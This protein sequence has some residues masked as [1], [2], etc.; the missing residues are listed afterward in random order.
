MGSIRISGIMKLLAFVTGALCGI[1]QREGTDLTC[2]A[3]SKWDETFEEQTRTCDKSGGHQPICITLT[4]DSGKYH[5]DCIGKEPADDSYPG[6]SGCQGE[7]DD[8]ICWRK[9]YTDLCNDDTD[10]FEEITT[11]STTYMSTTT[12]GGLGNS[13]ST[14]VFTLLL[15]F[16]Q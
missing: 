16:T 1:A 13:I 15:V 9:C 2:Y 12:S 8:R 3:Q 5:R 4:D 11:T 10:F 7:G 14:F 6:E